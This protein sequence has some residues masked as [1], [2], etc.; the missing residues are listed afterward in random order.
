MVIEVIL[1]F[2]LSFVSLASFLPSYPPLPLT[3]MVTNGPRGRTYAF[4]ITQRG[5]LCHSHCKLQNEC[6]F[7]SL[8]NLDFYQFALCSELPRKNNREI[9]NG[10]FNIVELMTSEVVRH[11]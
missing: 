9:Q 2:I 11:T 7:R 3:L 6:I 10:G 1:K 5:Q 4:V 8:I